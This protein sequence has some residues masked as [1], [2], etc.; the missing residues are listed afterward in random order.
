MHR[1]TCQA[2]PLFI[3]KY[4]DFFYEIQRDPVVTSGTNLFFD[5]KNVVF[6]C[7]CL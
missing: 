7:I 6:K 1:V 4:L 3:I 2:C 5:M